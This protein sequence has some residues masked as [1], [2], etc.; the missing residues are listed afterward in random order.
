MLELLESY[1]SVRDMD[2]Q[3]DMYKLH[4]DLDMLSLVLKF[5]GEVDWTEEQSQSLREYLQLLSQMFRKYSLNL[6]G[7]KIKECI[8]HLITRVE[9]A[10]SL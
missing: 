1:L 9:I 6:D 7:L 4:S 3:C 8:R 10:L 2:Q 5:S